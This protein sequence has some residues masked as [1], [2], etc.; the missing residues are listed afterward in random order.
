MEH[1]GKSEIRHLLL[2]G[3]CGGLT[4][5][6]ALAVESVEGAGGAQYLAISFLL[7]F[8][9]VALCIPLARKVMVV[10]S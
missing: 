9:V 2:P 5:F 4:T 10:N 7:S 1:R 8:T 3:F 6:S